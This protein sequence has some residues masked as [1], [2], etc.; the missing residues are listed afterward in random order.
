VHT[1]VCSHIYSLFLWL[2]PSLETNDQSE[3]VVD[4]N[5]HAISA[6]RLVRSGSSSS[7]MRS[8][9][10]AVPDLRYKMRRKAAFPLR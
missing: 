2:D 7:R 9:L 4:G 3:K 1:V 10:V 6:L 8:P 5:F